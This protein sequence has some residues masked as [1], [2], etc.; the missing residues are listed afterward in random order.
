MTDRCIRSL[1]AAVATVFLLASGAAFAQEPGVDAL[2]QDVE[3]LKRE[4]GE[5]RKLLEELRAQRPA[6]PRQPTGPVKVS[7]GNAPALGKADA[8]V[9]IVE[10]S[11]YQCP[12]CRRHAAQTLPELKRDYIDTGKVRYV[13]RD[14][15]IDSIHPEASKAAEAAHCAGDQGKY[16]EMHAALFRDIRALKPE[17]LKERA[18]GMGLDLAAF[19]AC[20]DGGRHAAR[21][22]ESVGAGTAVGVNGT[23][24]FFIG[25]TSADGTMEAVPIR[26]AQPAAAFRKVIDGLLADG[27]AS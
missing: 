24:A 12:F 6:Q 25:R 20:L 27:P 7:V 26:G 22:K 17:Q 23:P 5:I 4:L 15:P 9:T 13:M 14:F 3:Q 8:P 16:W 11:D 18:K 1:L 21:V 2:R 19:D 10:F